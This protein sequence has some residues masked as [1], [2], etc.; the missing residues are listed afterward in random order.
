[1]NR[2]SVKFIISVLTCLELCFAFL[3]YKSY[4]NE[5]NIEEVKEVNKVNKKQFA[6][7]V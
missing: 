4:S 3:T 2:K 7:Y 1:M 6:M 5:T